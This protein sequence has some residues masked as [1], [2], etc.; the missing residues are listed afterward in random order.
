VKDTDHDLRRV[1]QAVVQPRHLARPESTC[2]MC[3][4]QL[5]PKARLAGGDTSEC[6]EALPK[7]I[8]QE[9]T[10]PQV[11]DRLSLSVQHSLYSLDDV[12]AT[13]QEEVEELDVR[14][15]L[16]RAGTRSSRP[17]FR[18]RKWMKLRASRRCADHN[19]EGAPLMSENSSLLSVS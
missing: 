17:L 2:P 16:H 12:I 14:L 8:R 15:K 9:R 3:F 6:R 1:G 5:T 18:R 4:F 19:K 11:L 13:S 10:V 7:T